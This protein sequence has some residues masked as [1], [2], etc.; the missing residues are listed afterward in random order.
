MS[1]AEMMTTPVNAPLSWAVGVIGALWLAHGLAR[2]WID[3]QRERALTRANA[4]TECGADDWTVV[5]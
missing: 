2:W 3:A 4:G 1:P 5:P